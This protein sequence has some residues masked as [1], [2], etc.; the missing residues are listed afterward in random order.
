MAI[1]DNTILHLASSLDATAEVIASRI[2][3]RDARP[4]RRLILVETATIGEGRC[5]DRDKP[6]PFA[7]QG[8]DVEIC[9]IREETPESFAAQLKNAT[10][11]VL[12]GGNTFYLLEALENIGF[13]KIIR[14]RALFSPLPFHVIGESAG[15]VVMGTS[16]AHVASMDDPRAAGRPVD[17]GLGWV[18]SRVLP[19]RGCVHYGFGEAVERI[20][21]TDEDPDNLL[22]IDE[23]RV[24]GIIGALPI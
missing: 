4:D 12:L 5:V 2:A 19:H 21:A 20:I 16:I 1:P 17:Q 7:L 15:A 24:C 11:C 22:V 9:D 10:G 8:F 13:D 23:D 6:A 3:P 14:N 18:A